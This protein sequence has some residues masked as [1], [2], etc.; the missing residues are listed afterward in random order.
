MERRLTTIL[1]ADVVGYSRLMGEDEAGTLDAL[2]AHRKDIFDPKAEL[3]GGRIIKLMGDGILMEFASVVDTVSFAV[4]VQNSISALNKMSAREIVYRIGINIGDVIVEDDDIYGDGVNIAARLEGLAEPG[5]ICVGRN[6]RDQIRDKLDL[7]LEDLGE[8]EVKN[9]ARPVRAF[10]IAMD[11]RSLAL[12]SPALPTHGKAAGTSRSA[13]YM[14]LGISTLVVGA[15]I[16]WWQPWAPA[17]EPAR[18]EAMALPL[19]DKPSIAVLPFNDMSND[20]SQAQFTDGMT[21]DLI[22]DL[23]KVSGL[24]VI[25]RNSTFVYKGTAVNV[26][27]V[28]EDLGVRYVLEGSVRPGRRQAQGQCTTD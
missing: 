11:E 1:A 28:A 23:S 13:L 12:S 10:R 14:A 24:F 21:E 8:V 9:I 16:M 15:G 3:Y 27:K 20:E 7:T 4:D 19:P 17:F 26:K 18:T 22:T 5:G 25:A 2:R 6:V